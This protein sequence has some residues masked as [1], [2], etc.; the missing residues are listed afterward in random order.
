MYKQNPIKIFH[1]K[2]DICSFEIYQHFMPLLM[3]SS[4][5]SKKRTK[6]KEKKKTRRKI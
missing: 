2:K 4:P 1:R 5:Q 3:A 6:R